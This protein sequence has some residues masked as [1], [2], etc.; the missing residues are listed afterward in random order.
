MDEDLIATVS[1]RLRAEEPADIALRMAAVSVM[2]SEDDKPSTLLIM[3]AQRE[4]DPWSGQ[5]AFPGGKSQ[6][7]DGSAAKTAARETREEVGID[8]EREGR[9]LGY[10]DAATTH[11]G[12]MRV[13]PCVFALPARLEV[14]P[15]AEVA[16]HR[17]VELEGLLSPGAKSAYSMVVQGKTISLPAVR[18][19]D[20]LVWGLTHRIISTLFGLEEGP[21][22]GKR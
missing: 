13:I 10:A 4:G 6:P 15:N 18:V 11:T 12:T 9:F 8:L 3:R 1:R 20:Y 16:S 21:G 17:W 5:I 7:G 14:S 22:P 19:D 2:I